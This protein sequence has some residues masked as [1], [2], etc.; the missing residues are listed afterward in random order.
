MMNT[1]KEYI[2][3]SNLIYKEK[4]DLLT[5]SEADSLLAWKTESDENRDLYIRIH[6]E[7]KLDVKRAEYDDIDIAQAW[8]K[9]EP[10]I[11]TEKKTHKL[12]IEFIRYAAVL[13]LPL[14]IGSYLIYNAVDSTETYEE[15]VV[16]NI[17][18]GTQKASLILGNGEVIDLED[19][20]DAIIKTQDGVLVANKNS[21]LS[22]S[23][24]QLA[25]M[26]TRWHRLVVPRGGEYK[27]E[28][29]DGTKVWLNSDSELKY[30]DKF[31]GKE[32]IVYLKGEAYFDVAEDKE[33]AFIVK[34]NTM[35]VK[36]YGTEF[37]VMAYED[38]DLAQTTLVEGSVGVNLKNEIGVVDQL[39][40]K[41]DMQVDYKKGNA[42]G[43]LREVET[44]LYT[45]WKDGLFQFNDEDLGS[46]LK[47]LSRWYDVKVFFQ[48][49]SIQNIHFTGEMKRFEDFSTILNLLELGS[50]VQFDVKGKI[51]IVNQHIE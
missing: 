39:M 29:S 48:N 6:D 44:R 30:T 25:A 18:P 42:R 41:P 51:L 3:I 23:K 34:T 11:K 13:I 36:V 32:R 5:D 38:E 7:F 31:V 49:P 15:F 2:K 27:L 1:T 46:I 24:E 47:K 14:V 28:L 45:G 22:Y 37:N 35:D 12:F 33:H 26:Q 17:E 19:K 4:A 43:E 16:D 10:Q 50:G 21:K 40:L 8:N 20:G 9:I